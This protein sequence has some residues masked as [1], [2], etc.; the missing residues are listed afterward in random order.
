MSL[1]IYF[2]P[3]KLILMMVRSLE[4]EIRAIIRSNAKCSTRVKHFPDERMEIMIID[5]LRRLLSHRTLLADYFQK[6][7]SDGKK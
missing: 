7:D 2:S 3:K 1:K 6:I 5:E 4:H